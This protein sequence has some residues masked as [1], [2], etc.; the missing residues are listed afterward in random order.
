MSESS[1]G[2]EFKITLKLLWGRDERSQKGPKR[3]LTVPQIVAAAIEIADAEGLD[4]VSMRRV[5]ERLNVGAM[6]LYRYVPGKSELLELML[7]AIHAEPDLRSEGPWRD[8]LER[9]AR[10]T[11]AL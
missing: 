11:R 8:R 10:E 2:P 3:A 1:G 4:A 7:D 9:L 5:A 6:S